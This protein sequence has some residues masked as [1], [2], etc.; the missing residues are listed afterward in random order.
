MFTLC[1]LTCQVRVTIGNSVEKK[2][3]EVQLTLLLFVF[4]L[5]KLLLMFTTAHLTSLTSGTLGAL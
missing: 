3:N 4:E 1:L 2:E 5:E